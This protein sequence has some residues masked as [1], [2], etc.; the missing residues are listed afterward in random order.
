[1][2][3]EKPYINEQG[4]LIIP[5]NLPE[6]YKWWKHSEFKNRNKKNPYLKIDEIL[7]ELKAPYDVWVRYTHEKYRGT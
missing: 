6:Q 3:E 2:E 5:L 7:E 4:D 1:M